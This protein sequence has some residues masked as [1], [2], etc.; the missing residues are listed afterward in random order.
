[1][2]ARGHHGV[3]VSQPEATHTAEDAAK[4]LGVDV[5]AITKSLVFLLDGEQVLGRHLEVEL[6]AGESRWLHDVVAALVPDRETGGGLLVGRLVTRELVLGVLKLVGVRLSTQQ[7]AKYVPIAGQALSAALTYGALKYVC[8]QH[9]Q[10]CIAVSRQLQL[11]AP[12]ATPRPARTA[13]H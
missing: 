12:D 3:I 10:Q 7:A 1:M 2:I 11:P 13:R 5:G 4:A 9:I 8:E 6:G